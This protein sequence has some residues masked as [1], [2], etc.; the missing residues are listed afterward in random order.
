M[1]GASFRRALRVA[2]LCVVAVLALAACGWSEN[3]P[4][5]Q[6]L[7]ITGVDWGKDFHLVDVNGTPRS[8]ADY[9][10]KLV[11]LFFGYTNCPDACPTTL[12][13]MAQAVDRLGA[14]GQRVQGL[15]VTLDPARDTPA[16]LTQYV[17]AF[18]PNFVGL[19][20]DNATVAATAK[21]FKIFYQ[22]QKPDV[23]GFYTVDHSTALFVF[24]SRGRLRLFM[25]ASVSVDAIVHDLTLLLSE[26]S[27]SD[28]Q[29]T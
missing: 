10:G 26:P 3:K 25:G 19:S 16:V 4:K 21:D 15:L 14:H 11:M 5:F 7:D 22:L 17:P 12:A 27:A 1:S 29:A 23:N 2:T 6:T 9:R 18:H 28:Q 20:A 13:K 24:D 8:L